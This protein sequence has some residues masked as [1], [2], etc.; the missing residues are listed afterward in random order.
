MRTTG[1]DTRREFLDV[2][3]RETPLKQMS[4]KEKPNTHK[5]TLTKRDTKHIRRIQFPPETVKFILKRSGDKIRRASL[6]NCRKWLKVEKTA[7]GKSI[8]TISI[9]SISL[10]VSSYKIN[11]NL[12]KRLKIFRDGGK[13][14][15]P[16]LSKLL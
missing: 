9:L 10:L 5:Y 3:K 6:T 12:I 2:T 14:P 4:Q 13:A 11:E 8:P 1:P 15:P 7:R 16:H